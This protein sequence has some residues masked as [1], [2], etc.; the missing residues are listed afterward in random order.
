MKQVELYF[1]LRYNDGSPVEPEWIEHVGDRLLET[2]GGYTF[3]PQP[4]KGVWT[5]G[6]VTFH[7][8]VVIFRVLTGKVRQPK[9]FFQGLKKELKRGL[10]Q[11]EILIVAIEVEIF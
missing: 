10:Q 9:R 6:H 3:F 4:N 5:L 7:D 1:P 8:E 11:E 2:F